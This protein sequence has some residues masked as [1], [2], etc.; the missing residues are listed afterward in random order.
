VQKIERKLRMLLLA[1]AMI[2]AVFCPVFLF[3]Q[4]ASQTGGS[5]PA[6]ALT[7]EAIYGEPGLSGRLA[8]GLAW[9]PDSKQIA[10]FESTGTGKASRREV[11]TIDAE[12]GTRHLLIAADKLATSLP[13][14]PYPLRQRTGA[15]RR[16]PAPFQ[17]SP[18]GTAM[19]FRGQTSA[20]WFDLRSQTARTLC[21]VKKY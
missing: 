13:S 9:S 18:D 2:A 12:T 5:K 16:P 3:A 4:S 6:K 19:L 17:F 1:G 14:Q 11:W 15:A 7:I 8:S 10:F 21:R 20:V